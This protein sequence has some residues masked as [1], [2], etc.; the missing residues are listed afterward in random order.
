[1]FILTYCIVCTLFA[2][3]FTW[4]ISIFVLIFML[5]SL[6]AFV[7]FLLKKLL[8]CLLT[9]GK[10]QNDGR[11]PVSFSPKLNSAERP[12]WRRCKLTTKL[13]HQDIASAVIWDSLCFRGRRIGSSKCLFATIFVVFVVSVAVKVVVLLEISDVLVGIRYDTNERP[14]TEV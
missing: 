5:L 7:R 3:L 1:M 13:S 12:V 10:A 2:S 8:A 4:L 14:T 9:V 11:L 6:S